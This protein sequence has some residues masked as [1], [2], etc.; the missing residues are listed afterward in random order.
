MDG[1]GV[2]AR[3]KEKAISSI[4]EVVQTVKHPHSQIQTTDDD[5]VKPTDLEKFHLDSPLPKSAEFESLRTPGRQNP[6]R[7]GR[8][9]VSRMSASHDDSKKSRKSGRISLMG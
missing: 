6:Q 8:N 4:T 2:S 5:H 7:D 3:Q 9:E 1:F